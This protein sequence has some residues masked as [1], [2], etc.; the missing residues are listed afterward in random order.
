MSPEHLI[1]LYYSLALFFTV[2]IVIM[3]A[4]KDKDK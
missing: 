3:Y 4:S 1:L 2:I